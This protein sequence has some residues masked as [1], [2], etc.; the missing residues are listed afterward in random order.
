MR[1]MVEPQM[2][3]VQRWIEKPHAHEYA[4]MSDV[5]DEAPAA[6]EAVFKCL[7]RS[8]GNPKRGREG[9]GAEQVVR[10]LVVKQLENFSYDQLE[11]SLVDSTTFRTFCRLGD[12]C[13]CA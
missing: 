2:P 6:L 5:L 9:L 12:G 11:F 4:G 3:L 7:V 1:K 8:G 10:I 13:S